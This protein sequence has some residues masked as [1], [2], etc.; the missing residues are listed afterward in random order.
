MTEQAPRL[1]AGRND[2][3]LYPTKAADHVAKYYATTADSFSDILF[4]VDTLQTHPHHL[5]FARQ[6]FVPHDPITRLH[7]A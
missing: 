2:V 7:H 4:G 1:Q 3:A 6:G 5:D